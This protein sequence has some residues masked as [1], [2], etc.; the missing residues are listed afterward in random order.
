MGDQ[1]RSPGDPLY[2]QAMSYLTSRDPNTGLTPIDV[3][4]RK[5]RKWAAAQDAW[6]VAKD[7]ALST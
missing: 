5:Q 4:T 6:D 3:Y 1:L 2:V 7:E